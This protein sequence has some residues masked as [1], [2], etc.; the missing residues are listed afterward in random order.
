M[1]GI[2]MGASNQEKQ[3]YGNLNNL[4][5]FDS[6][7]GQGDISLGE[8]W[9][10][11]ILS[12]DP[13]KISK[14]LGPQIAGIKNRSQQSLQTASQFG[15]RSGGT[16]AGLQMTGDNIDSQINGMIDSL[17]QGAVG[18]ITSLGAN[19]VGQGAQNYGQV[20][21]EANTMQ[22]QEQ[23][24]WNDIFNSISGVVGAAAGMPGISTAFG[25][26]LSKVLT[27]AAGAIK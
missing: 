9:M 10:R 21:N 27:G 12:G 8:D 7:H 3:A 20:F 26:G 24:R 2:G 23:A 6:S 17:T 13:S 16:N 19:L 15:D 11:G 4:A 14:I 22:Q 1:F 18:G 5:G 25:G